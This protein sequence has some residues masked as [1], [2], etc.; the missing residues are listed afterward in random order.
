MLATVFNADAQ[1]MLAAAK[2]WNA[3]WDDV[4]LL[5]KLSSSI[6][7]SSRVAKYA[8]EQCTRAWMTGILLSMYL[9]GKAYLTTEDEEKRKDIGLML[10]KLSFDLAFCVIDLTQIRTHELVQTSMGLGSAMVA[11]Y[12]MAK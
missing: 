11:L 12:K 1:L 5:A 7:S 6:A 10:T 3:A 4:Q 8:F 9:E 2:T